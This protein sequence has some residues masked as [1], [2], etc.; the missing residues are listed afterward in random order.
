L[1]AR[2]DGDAE[3]ACFRVLQEALTNVARHAHASRVRVELR[4][5][6]SEIVLRVEDDGVGF[7]VVGVRRRRAARPSLGLTGMS[8]RMSTIGGSIELTSS[9]GCGT[10]I[11]AR[12]PRSVRALPRTDG[13][14]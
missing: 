9:P 2:L 6:A 7:D 3:L 5:T 11:V 13:V 4:R 14:Q 12:L 1:P 10:R 8:E